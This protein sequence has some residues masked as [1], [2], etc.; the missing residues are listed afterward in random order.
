[1]ADV[2][3]NPIVPGTTETS[4]WQSNLVG[5]RAERFV[6]WKRSRTSAVALVSPTAYVP[7]T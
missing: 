1:M 4:L 2:A 7:G 5:I 3:D 6:D